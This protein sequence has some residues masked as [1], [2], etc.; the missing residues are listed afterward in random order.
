[1]NAALIPAS[2]KTFLATGNKGEYKLAKLVLP[3]K[4]ESLQLQTVVA[5]PK[6]RSG[7]FFTA[8]NPKKRI[9]LHY[10]A[11]RLESDM[12]TLTQTNQHISVP[13]VIGRDGTIYQL[14]S[15]KQWSGHIGKGLG[16]EGT[17]NAQD[18]SSIGIE[19]SNYGFLI[20]R[21]G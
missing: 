4:N 7:Y 2:E 8:E 12:S 16:N 13:Y 3:V 5:S 17:A 18:K 15:P 1:M 9:V 10:T 20:E 6:S 19:I 21:D 14:F 11:G